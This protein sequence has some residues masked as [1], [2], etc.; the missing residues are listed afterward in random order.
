MKTNIKLL[1]AV[2]L[3]AGFVS[4]AN[5]QTTAYGTTTAVLVT[6]LSIALT[7]NMHFGLVASSGTAGTVVLGF[8]NDRIA[9]G[10]VTLPAA[11]TPP[12]P[13]AVFVVTGEGTSGF[14][15]A[16]PTTAVILTGS[17]SGTLSVGTF[18]CE[19]GASTTLTA[20]SATLH[21][22]AT[23][24]VPANTAAGTYVHNALDAT[25]LF[26]TVQYN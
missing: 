2:L 12:A 20:G 7:T 21:V 10:G 14:S 3:F 17:V 13:T 24:T 11:A 1:A 18:V 5:A 4:G 9:T 23:L 16:V 26:V 25:G 8:V 15:I 22:G 19:E 6:P